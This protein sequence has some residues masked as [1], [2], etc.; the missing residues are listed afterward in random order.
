MGEGGRCVGRWWTDAANCD[1]APRCRSAEPRG[2][3]EDSSCLWLSAGPW[4]VV[5]EDTRSSAGLTSSSRRTGT[6]TTFV[7]MYACNSD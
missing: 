5:C 3:R 2:R 7:S 6:V 4:I 1:E